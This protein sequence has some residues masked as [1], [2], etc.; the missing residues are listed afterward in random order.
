MPKRNRQ[1]TPSD[2]RT[3]QVIP[4]AGQCYRITFVGAG[5]KILSLKLIGQSQVRMIE[6]EGQVCSEC[7]YHG[8]SDGQ[9]SER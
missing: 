3:G 7:V 4:I 9:S 1:Q 2:I 8:G 6:R 5:Q